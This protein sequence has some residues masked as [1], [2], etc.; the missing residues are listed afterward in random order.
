MELPSPSNSNSRFYFLKYIARFRAFKGDGI[1][2]GSGNLW[3]HLTNILK[4]SVPLIW[5]AAIIALDLTPTVW[6]ELIL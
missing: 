3:I 1:G 4:R 5:D 2:K 6:V